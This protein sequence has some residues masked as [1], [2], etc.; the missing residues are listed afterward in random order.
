[1]S[2]GTNITGHNALLVSA[3]GAYPG[4][5]AATPMNADELAERYPDDDTRGLLFELLDI[6]HLLAQCLIRRD[7]RVSAALY[8]PIAPSPSG[9]RLIEAMKRRGVPYPEARMLCLLEMLHVDL[10]VDP[11]T[12]DLNRLVK[13]VGDQ[14][15]DGLIKYPYNYGRLLYDKA[16]EQDFREDRFTLSEGETQQLLENT[17]QGVFQIGAFVTG[18]YG[19]L[20]SEA[21]RYVPPDVTVAF[22]CSDPTCRATHRRWLTTSEEAPINEHR[23]K[24]RKQLDRESPDPSEWSEFFRRH[25]KP[26]ESSYNDLAGDPVVHL[27]GDALDISE[28]RSLVEWLLD[29]TDG[30]LRTVARQVQL[31]GKA[32]QI[33]AGQNEAELLQLALTMSNR[34]LF[35]ALDVLVSRGII[36]VPEGE[37]RQ[38]VVRDSGQFGWYHLRAQLG[39]YGVRLKSEATDIAP[40]RL[41]RL[42]GQMYTLDNR[43]ERHELEWQLRG[44]VADSL[45]ARIENYLQ[46]RPPREAVSA[47]LLARR[48]N[49]VVALEKLDLSEEILDNDED[50]INSV[51]WKLGFSVEDALDR[52]KDLWS[53]HARMVQLTRQSPVG[54]LAADQEQIRG[55]AASYF[56]QLEDALRDS[57]LYTTWALTNDHFASSP[58]FVYKPHVH[59]A[60]ALR[61]LK[62]QA[63]TDLDEEG[64]PRLTYDEK[65]PLYPLARGFQ[66]LSDYLA[67]C[68]TQK[69]DFL[70]PHKLLPHWV[71]VQDIQQFPFRHTMP[72]LDLLEESR[73]QIKERLR[74]ISRRLVGAEVSDA[75]NEWMHAR[76]SG[77]GVERLRSSLDAVRDAIVLIQDSGFSRQMFRRIRTEIDEAGRRTV[78]L[79]DGRGQE[80]VLFRPSHLQW[81]SLP[82]LD[83][84]QHLMICARFNEPTEVLRFVSGNDSPYARLWADYPARSTKAA[85]A[86]SRRL[87][88][89]ASDSY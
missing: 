88:V 78:V 2:A 47:L 29:N 82:R 45:E 53:L 74:E 57:L 54:P 60:Q 28:L 61:I 80:V 31:N 71:H 66:V 49:M 15:R 37:V 75:R 62:Q 32:T 43:E 58:P 17:P 33:T 6:R 20:R 41:R 38:S 25:A 79:A 83:R 39:K 16:R 84:T 52:H 68:E 1:M 77:L 10:L 4:G 27:L 48:S 14:I 87:H 11:V 63:S 7:Y 40:L 89:T 65:L 18:P 64:K 13:T 5:M 19:L 12:T 35:H 22:H 85:A 51:L 8:E 50:R 67:A 42:V 36:Y 30:D 21:N 26:E 9:M 23:P 56:V 72:F 24:V 73:I 69:E 44:E 59:E 3:R 34:R 86:L 46:S 55:Q 81:L 76:R 70:R